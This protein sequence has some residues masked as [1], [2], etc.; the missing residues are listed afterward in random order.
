MPRFPRISHCF[1]LL[2]CALL[3]TGSYLPLADPLPE[4]PAGIE[5]RCQAEQLPEVKT[6][7]AR[8][9][10]ELAIVPALY[11]IHED[12][13]AGV[14]RYTLATPPDQ[15]STLD[16]AARPEFAIPRQVVW[17][18]AGQGRERSVETVS[19]KEIVLALMQHGRLTVFAGRAC[20]AAALREH[21]GV[22]RNIV[23]WAESLEWGWPDGDKAQWNPVYW[24]DGRPRSPQLL[25]RAVNDVFTNQKAYRIGCYVAAKLVVVQGIVD[26]YNR[27]M[28]DAA[29]ARLVTA[30]LLADQEPLVGVEPGRMWDFEPVI[31]AAE[32]RRPGKVVRIGY[33]VAPLNFVPGDW[34]YFLNTDPATSQRTGYEGSNAIYLG[35]NRF[36]DYFNENDHAKSFAEKINEVYQ[37]RHHVFNRERDAHKVERLRPADYERLGRPPQEGGLLFDFRTAPYYFGFEELPELAPRRPWSAQSVRR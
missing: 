36:A 2:M 26:Y 19:A 23:A 17:L 14:L 10:S 8:Y 33:G 31:G 13:P 3:G 1:R 16:F 9:L 27:V 37:W 15:Y 7:M 35:R 12:A 21:V 11:R 4:Q 6:A 28:K 25:A 24:Q 32:L 29:K 22:R 20:T 18:P 34:P 30:R 5:F